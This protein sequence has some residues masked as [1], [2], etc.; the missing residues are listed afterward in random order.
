MILNA[1]YGYHVQANGDPLVHAAEELMK[2]SAI[3]LQ[4][5]WLVDFLTFREHRLFGFELPLN[6]YPLVS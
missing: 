6:R 1:V 2:V 5:G 3:A 4:A